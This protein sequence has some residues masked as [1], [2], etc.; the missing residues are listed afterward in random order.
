MLLKIGA[1][2]QRSIQVS[3][4]N[5][6]YREIAA[7]LRARVL[8][9]EFEPGSTL[10]TIDE[11][12]AEFSADKNTILRAIGVLEAEGLL[13]AVPKRGTI[14]RRGMF[15]PHMPCGDLVVLD[16]ATAE[17]TYRFAPEFESGPWQNHITPVVGVRQLGDS[18]IAQLLKVSVD[19]KVMFR[20]VVTGPEGEPP[21]Q[22]STSW[23]HPR[24]ADVSAVTGHEP[25]LGGWLYR[26]EQAGHGP[27]TWRQHY[28]ARVPRDAE[29]TELQI[30][31]AL[32]VMEIVRVSHSGRDGEPVEVTQ[33]VIP[34]DRAEI[35]H[36][37]RAALS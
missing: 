22:G 4:S 10:P 6:R 21:F 2:H 20:H 13:R 12:A 17:P 29:P 7:S 5:S 33:L 16:T 37:L 25:G 23:I 35:V 27:L 36:Q 31:A 34:A 15:R 32:P 18:R 24:V 8:A 9:G 3:S 11:L 1:A 19:S 28:R 26:I 30:P 14:I